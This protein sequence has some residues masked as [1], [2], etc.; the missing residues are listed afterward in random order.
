M[1][2]NT[3]TTLHEILS[4]L[5]FPLC[6]ENFAK[7]TYKYYDSFLHLGNLIE[8]R[9]NLFVRHTVLYIITKTEKTSYI[10][11]LCSVLQNVNNRLRV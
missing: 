5:L 11:E 2:Q 9:E 7:L 4:L 3:K 8:S 1:V 6:T 10:S